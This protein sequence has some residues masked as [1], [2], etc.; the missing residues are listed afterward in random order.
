MT[1]V[2][3]RKGCEPFPLFFDR[4]DGKGSWTKEGRVSENIWGIR[5]LQEPRTLGKNA[6]KN[7]LRQLFREKG[8]WGICEK[9]EF[10]HHPGLGMSNGHS[11]VDQQYGCVH[12][13]RSGQHEAENTVGDLF[14]LSITT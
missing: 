11:P 10:V 2:N 5:G 4:R 3:H 1:V 9:S 6:G 8:C 7:I 14:G 12:V 13:R